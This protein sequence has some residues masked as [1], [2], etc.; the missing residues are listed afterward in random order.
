MTG[1]KKEIRMSSRENILKNIKAN[2][3]SLLDLPEID[4]SIFVDAKEDQLSRFKKMIEAVG[5]N[6]LEV[7]SRAEF[8]SKLIELF[9]VSK[10]NYYR[11]KTAPAKGPGDLLPRRTTAQEVRAG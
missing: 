2:K 5:G 9:P 4:A 3:P 1:I 6:L 7:N 10:N 11:E 8:V